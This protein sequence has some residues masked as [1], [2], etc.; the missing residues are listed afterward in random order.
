MRLKKTK[1]FFENKMKLFHKFWKKKWTR[2]GAVISKNLLG[3]E[4]FLLESWIPFVMTLLIPLGV[5]FLLLTEL[6]MSFEIVYELF[7]KVHKSK[8]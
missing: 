6:R 7:V 4:F 2:L 1:F 3:K 5:D 8:C